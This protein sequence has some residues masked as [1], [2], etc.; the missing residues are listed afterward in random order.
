[1]AQRKGASSKVINT[2]INFTS[3][4]KPSVRLKRFSPLS[5]A[6]LLVFGISAQQQEINLEIQSEAGAMKGSINY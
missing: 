1:V 6:W 3:K 5:Y 2:N 4:K